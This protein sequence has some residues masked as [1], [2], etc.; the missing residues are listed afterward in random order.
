MSGDGFKLQLKGTTFKLELLQILGGVID[1]TAKS[2]IAFKTGGAAVA[3]A[4]N[5]ITGLFAALKGI[6]LEETSELRAWVLVSG[7]L[8]YAL[9]KA[10]SETTFS[11]DPPPT[12]FRQLMTDLGIRIQTKT[13][14]IEPGF[15]STPNELELLEDV[16]HELSAWGSQFGGKDR[17]TE[18]RIKIDRHFSVGLHRTWMKNPSRF[19][20]LEQA[21][22]SPFVSSLR[23]Q[24]EFARSGTQISQAPNCFVQYYWLPTL[25]ARPS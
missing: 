8:L 5:L 23:V 19:E 6:K 7:G 18:A 10:I 16:S 11:R 15:F 17:S 14:T 1:A 20:P 25:K 22:E 21:L 9:E 3:I 24:Q 13:Y 12:A 2:F 4:P